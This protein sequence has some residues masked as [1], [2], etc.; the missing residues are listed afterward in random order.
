MNNFAFRYCPVR[1]IMPVVVNS[2]KVYSTQECNVY[3]LNFKKDFN[4]SVLTS[5]YV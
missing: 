2:A 3:K 5:L 1:G 4:A